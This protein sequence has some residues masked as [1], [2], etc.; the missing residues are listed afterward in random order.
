MSDTDDL[1]KVLFRFNSEVFGEETVETMWAQVVDETKGWYKIDNIPFYALL[2]A[3]NDVVFAEYDDSEQMLTYRNTV[4]Y[5]GNST[6]WV[7]IMDKSI[8]IEDIRKNFEAMGCESEKVNEGYFAMDIP[9]KIE[10]KTIKLKL[11]EL[12]QYEFIEYAEPCLSDKHRH[13]N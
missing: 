6:V 4:E 5:S 13:L 9:A 7:V 8:R 1:V 12:E 10:Y 3:S 2:I 11:Q